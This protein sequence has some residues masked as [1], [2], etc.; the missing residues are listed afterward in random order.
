MA[1]MMDKTIT[2][3]IVA[4]VAVLIICTCFI[5]VVIDQVGILNDTYGDSVAMYTS[6][7]SVVVVIV[8]LSIIIMVL[9][10]YTNHSDEYDYGER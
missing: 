7:I 10:S 3:I 9:R 2:V 4:L 8:I 5:P 1:D 6:M